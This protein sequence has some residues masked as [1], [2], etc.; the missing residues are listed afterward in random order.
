MVKYVQLIKHRTETSSGYYIPLLE[1]VDELRVSNPVNVMSEAKFDTGTTLAYFNSFL[2]SKIKKAR[3]I[4]LHMLI[5]IILTL[6]I[7]QVIICG[8]CY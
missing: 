1:E 4:L 5:N 7:Q 6:V 2:Y 8:K 3:N